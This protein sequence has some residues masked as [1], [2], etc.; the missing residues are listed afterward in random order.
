MWNTK[1]GW[2]IRVK[3]LYI[4]EGVAYVSRRCM[5]INMRQGEYNMFL[6]TLGICQKSNVS[7]LKHPQI[8]TSS[9]EDL[10]TDFDDRTSW[11]HS[12]ESRIFHHNLPDG[13]EAFFSSRPRQEFLEIQRSAVHAFL[14]YRSKKIDDAKLSSI[15]EMLNSQDTY[16][17]RLGQSIVNNL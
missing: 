13:D 16:S 1:D 3:E 12:Y 4:F 5:A 17:I 15:M 2:A 8:I 14:M 10:T 7:F 11:N 9:L 6:K